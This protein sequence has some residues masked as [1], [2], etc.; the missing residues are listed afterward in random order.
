M[1]F[2]FRVVGKRIHYLWWGLFSGY[3]KPFT[4]IRTHIF[5]AFLGTRNKNGHLIALH[6]L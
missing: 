2:E 3:V 6:H 4:N 5:V 1:K